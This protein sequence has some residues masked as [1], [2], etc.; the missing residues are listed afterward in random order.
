MKQKIGP[1]TARQ[2]IAEARAKLR[3]LKAILRA[4]EFGNWATCPERAC[5]RRRLCLG[6]ELARAPKPPRPRKPASPAELKHPVH[7]AILRGASQI[8]RSIASGY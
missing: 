1:I 8:V 3:R 2:T 7:A 6:L 4:T 5:R